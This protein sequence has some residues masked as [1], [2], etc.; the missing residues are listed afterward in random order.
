V[1]DR[2]VQEILARY[3]LQAQPLSEPEYLAGAGGLSGA[4]LWRYG[5]EQGLLV[6]RAWPEHG[7]GRSQLE[8]IHHWLF[9]ASN[10]GFI[11][12]PIR[13]CAGRTLQEYKGRCWEVTPWLCGAAPAGA[14]V[15]PPLVQSAFTA[16]AALHQCL[17]VEQVEGTSPGLGQRYREIKQ[18]TSGGFDSIEAAILCATRSEDT[19]LVQAALRWVELARVIAPR[20]HQPLGLAAGRLLTLQ[21]CL[22]DV[23]PD[24]F[25]FEGDRVRGLVD[26]G[27]MGI[28]CVAGDLARL[29]PEWLDDVAARARA[30]GA[31]ERIRPLTA[32][33]ADLIP[34]FESATALLIGEHWTRWH[35]LENRRF[36]DPCAVTRGI[37]RSLER[38][39]RLTP[40]AA[41]RATQ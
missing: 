10:L 25:L 26:F 12:V 34:I 1:S 5:C 20:I 27:A 14:A 13:D 37:E 9:R 38:M 3:P 41:V 32:V 35:Y 8:H 31:Y 6:L 22:R 16:L 29:L 23:R 17:A 33:E 7:P 39:A 24:H 4:R 28:D 36:D 2:D 30:L 15:P 19:E 18:L 11:P 21:P 40:R